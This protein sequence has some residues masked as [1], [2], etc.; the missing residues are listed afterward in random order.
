M[1]PNITLAETKAPNGARMTL[2]EHDGSYCIRVNGQQLMHSSVSSSEIKLGE[3][4]LAR[5]RK[6][7][8]GTRVLIGGLGLGF[9]LKSVLEATGG[10][11]T[12]HVAELFPEIVAW[13]RTHL[14]K[15]NGH[16]LADKRVKVL[17]EDV[18]TI[19]AK[20]VRQPFDVIVL[21]I[22]N[23]TT[24][25]VKTENIELYSER[26]MQL[27]FR[28]LKP[29]GRAAVWSACPDVT[30][31]RRLTKAGFK[32]EAVPAKLYETAKR[33]AYMIYVADKPVE[34]VSP[35]KAKG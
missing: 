21:D 13:N 28:A 31:E 23:G 11:G 6:L 33:F 17:E 12:V 32:V 25:M 26:G 1:K 22:D 8:N 2:V 7:N 19:L 30:I 34:E 4:G 14:A 5:H 16:L 29:G 15:L 10:N 24:A 35:K 3:L 9:T 27:I 20:A 18:R